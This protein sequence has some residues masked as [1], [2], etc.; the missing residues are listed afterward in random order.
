MSAIKALAHEIETEQAI[1]CI[2]RDR[3]TLK[4]ALQMALR[5]ANS[6]FNKI[7]AL[8]GYSKRCEILDNI[9]QELSNILDDI[10]WL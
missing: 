2:D 9:E 1:R 8:E 5:N 4:I 7:E 3:E 10:A 6:L